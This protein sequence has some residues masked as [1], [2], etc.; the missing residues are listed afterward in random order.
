MYPYACDYDKWGFSDKNGNIKVP[1]KYE[2]SYIVQGYCRYPQKIREDAYFVRKRGKL[3]ILDRGKETRFQEMDTLPIIFAIYNHYIIFRNYR[4][5]E[6]QVYLRNK[7]KLLHQIF[8]QPPNID[9]L[10][11]QVYGAF[12]KDSSVVIDYHGKKII[13]AKALKLNKYG[14]TYIAYEDYKKLKLYHQ[15]GKAININSYSNLERFTD[16][17]NFIF[18][19]ENEKHIKLLY[20]N[21]TFFDTKVKIENS[22]HLWFFHQNDISLIINSHKRDSISVY[23]HKGQKIINKTFKHVFHGE[24]TYLV[25]KSKSYI[26]GPGNVILDSINYSI[27]DRKG[28]TFI[29]YFGNKMGTYLQMIDSSYVFDE[30][31][32]FYKR[33]DGYVFDVFFDSLYYVNNRFCKY[34]IDYKNDTLIYCDKTKYKIESD[35]IFDEVNSCIR[36]MNH[37]LPAKYISI[38]YIDFIDYIFEKGHLTQI[39]KPQLFSYSCPERI[40]KN[41]IECIIDTSFV[42]YNMIDNAKKY[43]E[44][45]NERDKQEALEKARFE[46]NRLYGYLNVNRDTIMPFI[47]SVGIRHINFIT[48]EKDSIWTVFDTLTHEKTIYDRRHIINGLY[49]EILPNLFFTV[50]DTSKY[51]AYFVYHLEHGLLLD[52]RSVYDFSDNWDDFMYLQ[53]EENGPEKLIHAPSGVLIDDYE[54]YQSFDRYSYK[55]NLEIFYKENHVII[56]KDKTHEIDFLHLSFDPQANDGSRRIYYDLTVFKLNENSLFMNP[57]TMK[58]LASDELMEKLRIKKYKSIYPE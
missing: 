19:L 26:I 55:Y 36:S 58:F 15:N 50:A 54:E 45:A 52:G 38:N 34:L 22:D 42:K 6:Y 11:K 21:G 9:T 35:F 23:N 53:F 2:A 13:I 24:N 49:N 12:V 40:T 37:Y 43:Q 39:E 25:S 5:E 27:D 30:N 57:E 41:N 10:N 18:L 1:C 4:K 28:N 8:I 16:D 7:K 29:K 20:P 3:Y 47:Y 56:S 17:Q 46:N 44:E 14:K 32:R 48:F 33:F 31:L 51:I